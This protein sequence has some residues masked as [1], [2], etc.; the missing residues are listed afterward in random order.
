MPHDDAPDRPDRRTA[1]QGYEDLRARLGRESRVLVAFSGGAD[2][3]LLAVVAHRVL[4]AAAV[5]VTAVSASLPVAERRAAAALARREG[6]A[7]VEVCTDEL[8]RPGYVA[9]TGDRCFHCKSAL[10]DAVAPLAALSGA[11][12][13]LGTNLDDLG[14]HRPGQRAAAQRGA[15]APLVDAGL[16]KAAVREISRLIGLDTADKPAAACLSSRIA[17]GDPVTAE[18][19][20]RIEAAEEALHRLGFPVGRVRAHAGGTVARLELP[21]GDLDR[22]VLVREEIDEAVRAAGFT[23]CALDTQGFRS[24]RMNVLL[25]VPPVARR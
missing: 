7:H 5:A 15:I 6:L 12:V 18:V 13:A 16:S 22:A 9:N 25:G 10:F 2:S 23:F 1:E 11:V 17:Y 19:L 3:A 4:G 8:T 20:A 24:G 14:D 21:A